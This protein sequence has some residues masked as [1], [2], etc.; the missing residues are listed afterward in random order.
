MGLGQMGNT[1]D[2]AVDANGSG[3]GR[4]QGKRAE[5]GRGCRGGGEVKAGSN[6]GP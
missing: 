6:L 1:R 5:R 3:R 4:V 2:S